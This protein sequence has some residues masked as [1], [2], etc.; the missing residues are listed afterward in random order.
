M[1]IRDSFDDKSR[2]GTIIGQML[3]DVI[4]KVRIEN[5]RRGHVDCDFRYQIPRERDLDLFREI[6]AS[7]VCSRR[8]VADYCLRR[9]N[10]RSFT[11][12]SIPPPS[13]RAKQLLHLVPDRAENLLT[14]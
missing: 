7:A 1:C 10:L 4:D 14:D 12:C 6:A 2:K 5:H 8:S 9:A 3:A 11:Q 13:V